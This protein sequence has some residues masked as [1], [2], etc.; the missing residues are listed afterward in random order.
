MNVKSRTEYLT[1]HVAR[2]VDFVNITS[3]VADVVQRSG[4]QEGPGP[5]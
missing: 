3:Q 1:F 2:R 5:I 4:V